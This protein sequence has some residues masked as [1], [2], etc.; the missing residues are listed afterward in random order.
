ML[1]LV[2]GY[3]GSGCPTISGHAGLSGNTGRD[4]DDLS[5]GQTFAET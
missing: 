1:D 4:E 2:L 5:A 3:Q